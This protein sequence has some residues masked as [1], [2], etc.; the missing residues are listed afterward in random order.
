MTAS[1][2][3]LPPANIRHRSAVERR[4][5]RFLQSTSNIQ[6]S[7]CFVENMLP[8]SPEHHLTP[9]L[10]PTSWRRG[11][12]KAA[13]L[14][15]HFSYSLSFLQSTFDIR[16]STFNIQ[17][18]ISNF[19]LAVIGAATSGQA[20]GAVIKLLRERG[21]KSSLVYSHACQRFG[22]SYLMRKNI[23]TRCMRSK[24]PFRNNAVRQ[25][26]AKDRFILCGFAR[27]F[28]NFTR[29]NRFNSA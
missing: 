3:A 6:H 20:G 27:S 13:G 4:R 26:C 14:V 15:P 5:K 16:H 24:H 8:V 25:L 18:S 17:C 9:A 19:G 2:A 29:W 22:R 23:G 10:S 7:T 28:L 12:R 11:R 1:F 21:K